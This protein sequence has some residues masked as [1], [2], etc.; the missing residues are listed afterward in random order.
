M[1]LQV[2]GGTL[3]AAV[4][5]YTDS[6]MLGLASGVSSCVGG[7]VSTIVWDDP[8]VPKFPEGGGSH[9]IFRRFLFGSNHKEKE[10]EPP[11]AHANNKVVVSTDDVQPMLFV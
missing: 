4:R 5:N 9:C 1:A 8:M 6:V 3:Y 7:F 10:Q 11:P 2:C